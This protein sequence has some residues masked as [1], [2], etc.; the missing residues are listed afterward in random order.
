MNN[1]T[2]IHQAKGIPV[3]ERTQFVPFANPPHYKGQRSVT[4]ARY[5]NNE[6]RVRATSGIPKRRRDTHEDRTNK[7]KAIQHHGTDTSRYWDPRLSEDERRS[8]LQVNGVAPAYPQCLVDFPDA[9]NPEKTD[10][11]RPGWGGLP[12]ETKF[13]REARIKVLRLGGTMEQLYSTEEIVFLTGT[14]PGSTPEAMFGISLMS[15]Y[16]VDCLLGW[17]RKKCT[18]A[19]AEFDYLHCW[20]RQKRGALHIHLAFACRD[21]VVRRAV[22]S[23]F[24]DY[25][26]G[27]LRSISKMI[28]IDLF[29]REQGKK[30]LRTWKDHPEK[31]QADASVVEKS[32]AAYLA[33]YMGKEKVIANPKHP[34]TNS[35][36]PSRWW[37][38]SLHLKRQLNELT[39]IYSVTLGYGQWQEIQN[40]LIALTHERAARPPKQY[41]D[42]YGSGHNTVIYHKSGDACLFEEIVGMLPKQEPI[43]PEL[44]RLN[45]E[46]MRRDAQERDEAVWEA[47]ESEGR[48]WMADKLEAAGIKA[49]LRQW[50]EQVEREGAVP[51][52][53]PTVTYKDSLY[54]VVWVGSQYAGL[55]AIDPHRRASEE[56]FQIFEADVVIKVEVLHSHTRQQQARGRP[57]T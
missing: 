10:R 2:E 34:Y 15:G 14:L 11:P 49:D 25:W 38:S 57:P 30:G 47:I 22:L 54:K 3:R 52:Y 39:E 36:Y 4:I 33:K 23:Q 55:S 48:H 16:L 50:V 27:L 51:W 12:Q 6:I 31:V 7:F 41:W 1:C 45:R 28:Q 9:L 40:Q 18:R 32:V 46:L 20:E 17:L 21:E 8:L 44:I 24:H 5:P 53:A 35:F 13:H 26:V 43:N 29:E 56:K 42:K 19:K 37:G